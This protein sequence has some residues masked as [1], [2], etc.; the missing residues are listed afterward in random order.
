MLKRNIIPVACFTL[1]LASCNQI[2]SKDITVIEGVRLGTT[3]DELYSQF[4]S[5]KIPAKIFFTKI[6]FSAS[7]D[8]GQNKFKNYVTD[9][10]NSSN[11]GSQ[12]VQHYGLYYPTTMSGTK[13]VVSLAIL[14][15]HTSPSIAISNRG[16]THLTK[17]TNIPGI[18]QDISYSQADDI[19]IMLSNKYGKPSD[20]LKSEYLKFYV[21]KGTQ[22]IDYH[23]DSSNIGELLIWKTKYV[24]VKYFKGISS[25]TNTFD[26]KAHSY[27]T[28][29]DNSP[30]RK[31]DYDRG[32]RPCRSYSYISYELNDEAIKKLELDKAK[33]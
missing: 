8:I 18:G 3:I 15:I 17:E 26:S 2:S 6:I 10:F 31:I 16:I 21:I 14:L 27:T 5:L 23:S 30:F 22:I 1:V 4:D 11:Y 24:D 32:E 12:F 13:N 25:P 20:T 7:D 19:A 33:L 28:Y 9:L 29:F